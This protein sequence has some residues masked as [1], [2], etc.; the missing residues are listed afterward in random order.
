MDDPKRLAP[1]VLLRSLPATETT[2]TAPLP[3]D[4]VDALLAA[5]RKRLAT[6]CEHMEQASKRGDRPDIWPADLIAIEAKA[7][8]LARRAGSMFA[9]NALCDR[10]A[11]TT[12]ETRALWVL[13]GVELCPLIRAIGRGLSTEHSADPTTD[14]IRRAVYGHQA[15]AA[16]WREL[17]ED[18]PL[19]RY[20]LIERSDDN[21]NAPDHRQ[22]WKVSGRVLALVHGELGLDPTVAAFATIADDVHS[23][24]DLALAANVATQIEQSLDSAEITIAYGASG[25]GR[26]TSLV[27]LAANRGLRILQIDARGI[28]KDLEVARRQCV[29]LSRECRLLS[30]T[31]L[32]RD[33]EALCESGDAP[34]RHK[35]VETTLPG[36]LLAT[37]SQPIARRWTRSVACV[38]VGAI[39]TLQRAELWRRA[40]PQAGTGDANI[41]A[42]AYPIAPA[43]I[44]TVGRL[45]TMRCGTE[46]MQPQHIT[47]AMRSVLDDRLAGLA[48][49]VHVTQSWDDLVLPDD[50]RT[51]ITELLSRIRQRGRV[52][53]EWGFAAKVG[54]GL[55]VAAL[56]SGPPGTGKTMVAGLVARE[57]GIEL[58]QV[59]MSKIVSKW[60]GETE[61]NLANLFD[62]A[63]AGNAMLLFDEADALFGKRSD[64]KSS[65]DRHANQETNFLL[66]RLESYA[67]ICILTTNH[68]TAIDDAFR[69]R[70]AVHVRF[71]MPDADERAR[72]WR[73]LLPEAAP[74]ADD[75]KL[76]AL[77]NSYAMTGGHIRNAV[78]RAA[79]LAA[80]EDGCID[81]ARLS[82]AAQL[83]YEALGK[84]VS[85]RA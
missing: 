78:L 35:L 2:D 79:F 3:D 49:R 26:R 64:V 27:A 43:L 36:P 11:L 10:F 73:A 47:E 52:Y 84:I 77:A 63:E 51:A 65:N 83:E 71:S 16:V 48:R 70:L 55:G 23:V 5:I 57:L 34:D 68:E 24:A 58:Y 59:D 7:E 50:Q 8:A 76:E 85:A 30:L 38:E 12:T 75:L 80:D 82:R 81:A 4:P 45:A 44:S 53:E 32:F 25:S 56:F 9:L 6:A 69:R 37:A 14:A 22:T 15:T 19:R 18:G 60:I 66:Q 46:R 62:V 21:A 20:K 42:N 13:I 17:G 29:A 1:S 40:L 72:L 28:S 33:F 67:G 54:R 61:K 31:P 41:L 39:S 74:R